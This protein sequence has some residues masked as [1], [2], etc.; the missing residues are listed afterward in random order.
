MT[1]LSKAALDF[2]RKQGAKGGKKGGV[3]R[4]SKL[5]V[6]ERTELAKRAAAARWGA[7]SKK[8]KK[9]SDARSK[10]PSK[11]ANGQ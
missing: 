2:F 10:Q 11:E 8:A 4:M 5:T 6:E 9:G 7:K 1:K 3:S